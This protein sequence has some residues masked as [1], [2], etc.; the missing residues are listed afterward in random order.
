[1]RS[2]IH[3]IDLFADTIIILRSPCENFAPWDET[4]TL[5]STDVTEA[6]EKQL[7]RAQT[8]ENEQVVRKL[9][10]KEAKKLAKMRNRASLSTVPSRVPENGGKQAEPPSRTSSKEQRLFQ[11]PDSAPGVDY[12]VENSRVKP[13]VPAS[14]PITSEDDEIHYLVSSRHLMLASPWFRRVL[15]REGFIKASK[16]PSDRRYHIPA[17]SWDEEAFLILLNVFY[18]RTR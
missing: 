10:K 13:V 6:K 4:P 17:S 14:E 5:S 8:S 1:M 18:V 3:E 11:D 15:T 16:D 12:E 9:S 2:T 7:I